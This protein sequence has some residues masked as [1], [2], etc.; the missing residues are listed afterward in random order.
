MASQESYYN[1]Q[2]APLCNGKGRLQ[3]SEN[4][5]ALFAS[6][7]TQMQQ[8][9]NAINLA[10]RQGRDGRSST[11]VSMGQVMAVQPKQRST[12][13]ETHLEYF[14]PLHIALKMEQRNALLASVTV[15]KAQ[16][17]ASTMPTADADG[18][19]YNEPR[20]RRE[21]TTLV[22][23]AFSKYWADIPSFRM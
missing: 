18:A 7:S 13:E 11:I 12:G 22:R 17:E 3:A 10:G 20:S 4:A 19:S 5:R 1:L 16:V 9:R 23:E 2:R 15:S 6:W 8:R 14:P 21:R